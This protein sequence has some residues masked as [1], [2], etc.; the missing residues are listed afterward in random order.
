MKII[1]FFK[2][3]L[4]MFFI[5]GFCL[6]FKLDYS[7]YHRLTFHLFKPPL[8]FFQF[9]NLIYAILISLS[10]TEIVSLYQFRN[11]SKN[12]YFKSSINLISFILIRLFFNIH[13]LL[14]TFLSS[15]LLFISLLYV[16]EEVSF[17][18]EKSTRYLDI[19]VLYSVILSAFTFCLYVLNS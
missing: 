1:N 16:Y 6:L 2:N 18:N 15:I 12:F 10:L 4:V 9:F 17:L 3:F 5:F 7:F 14:F 19:N 11:L 8:S 13:H